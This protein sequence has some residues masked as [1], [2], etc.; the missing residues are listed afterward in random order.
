MF[1][2]PF[3]LPPG[4]LRAFG[5]PGSRRYVGLFWEPC[6]D[7]CCYDDGERYA[8]GCCDNWMYLDFK[9]QPQVQQ[10]LSD[11]GIHLGN[12]DERARHWLIADALTGELYAAPEREAHAAVRQQQLPPSAQE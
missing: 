11:H 10:Y 1:K 3:V 12:S 2:T 4:W 6:G 8:C 9:R 7:E 5:Y